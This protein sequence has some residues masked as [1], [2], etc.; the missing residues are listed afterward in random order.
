MFAL[1][2]I[3]T[4]LTAPV[5]ALGAM[6]AVASAQPIFTTVP[7]NIHGIPVPA[8]QK[9]PVEPPKHTP[10]QTQHQNAGTLSQPAAGKAASGPLPKTSAERRLTMPQPATQV[11]PAP[12]AVAAATQTSKP[13]SPSGKILRHLTNSIQG[14]RLA[15]EI[16]SLERPVY[17]TE[18]QARGP[19]QFQ[20][21]YISA[22]SVMPEA[23]WLKLTV[24][25]VVVGRTNILP[26]PSTRMHVFEI[27]AGLIQPGFNSIRLSA[28][29]HHRV[30]CSIPATYELWTQMDPAATGFLL[31]ERDQGIS[32]FADLAALP[33]DAQGA[34]PVRIVLPGRTDV[35]HLERIFRAVQQI[36]LVGRF[37]QPVIDVGDL[38]K[39]E[40]GINLIIGAPAQVRATLASAYGKQGELPPVAILPP[41][42]GYRTTIVISGQ[43]Y[44]QIDAALLRFATATDLRGAPA[45]LRAARAFPGY[46]IAGGQRVR[47]KDLGLSSQEFGGRLFRAEFN[48]IMPPDFYAADYGKAHLDLAG[49]YA[50][51]LTNAAQ[52][53]VSVNGRN[54][55]SQKL[56]KSSG[57]VF[58]QNSIPLQLG[59]LRPGLN[60]IEIEAQVPVAED[61]A[62]DPLKAISGRKRFLFLDTTELEIPAIARIAR[63]PDLAVTA[64][65]GFPFTGGNG[66]P[67]IYIPAPDRD[68]IGAAATLISHLA[69]AAGQ[70][71]NFHLSV[72][73]PA[74]GSG[75]TLAV[76]PVRELDD[77]LLQ[78]AGLKREEI[79]TVWQSRFN[80]QA[81][82]QGEEGLSDWEKIARRRLVMQRNFPASCHMPA[83]EGGFSSAL[84]ADHMA[85]ASTPPPK[86]PE[87]DLFAEWDNNVRNQSRIFGYITGFARSVRDWSQGAFSDTRGWLDRKFDWS[88]WNSP[89]SRASSLIVAQNIAG[90]TSRH[91]WTVVTAPNGP[92]LAQSVNCLTDPRVWRQMAGRI[93]VLNAADGAVFSIAAADPTLIPTQPLSIGNVRLIVAGWFSLNNKIYVFL[94]LM[95][96]VLLAF[97]TSWFVNNVGRRPE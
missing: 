86:A 11:A 91:V 36:S 59:H 35:G 3:I 93:A 47:L 15:G 21:G 16:A 54:A 39:G 66:V 63:V 81:A 88:G 8:V 50:P 37:E 18:A 10:S 52:I 42:D 79:Y 80:E 32:T 26:A 6:T 53:V 87:R 83:P 31:S 7:G 51:G 97:A 38:A 27:P 56:P 72:T 25:D 92:L 68:S 33:P 29:Q 17:F 65:G 30:D 95:L 78:M 48:I 64:T 49:G 9:K 4:A 28:D 44:N 23:S 1:R 67:N 61:Q 13:S 19:I 41:R 60:R 43:D 94:A 75:P 62:C 45:G 77:D 58:K 20:A 24:N 84:R 12:A 55:V 96:A 22:V 76:A 69:I 2:H 34:L 71:I 40:Y 90:S 70:T 73:K 14:F 46:R 82:P 85:V 89:L 57:D 5:M 74:T